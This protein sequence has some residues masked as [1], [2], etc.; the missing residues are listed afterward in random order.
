MNVA[1][2]ELSNITPAVVVADN[3]Q[4]VIEYRPAGTGKTMTL[5]AKCGEEALHVE[6]LDVT[7]SNSRER[8]SDAVC[9]G[10]PGIDRKAVD[11]EL[12]RIAAAAAV[13]RGAGGGGDAGDSKTLEEDVPE[14]DTRRIVR[15]ERFITQQVSGLAVPTARL[16][17]GGPKGQYNLY[18]RDHKDGRRRSLRLP[19]AIDLPSESG[20]GE[21]EKLLIHPRPSEPSVKQQCG[22][23]Q[24]ARRAWVK[25]SVA[26]DPAQVFKAICERFAFFLHLPEQKAPGVTATLSLWTMLTYIYPAFNAVP[27]LY[28]GGP[29]GSGKS[30]VF[31]VLSRLV[32]RP[33]SSSSLTAASLFRTL[34]DRGGTL[35]LDEAE[36]LKQTSAPDVGE[37]LSMLLAGYKRGGQAT[38][39]EPVG[40]SFRTVSFDVYG[41]KVLGCINGLPP[42][43][44]S[45]AIPVTMFR[46]PPGSVKPRHRIDAVP[47]KWQAIR[48]DLH[49]LALEHGPVWLEL[50][51]RD[52]VCSAMSG[53]DFE[54]WQPLLS[55]A[56]W[57]E[58]HGASGLLGL[59]QDHASATIN[60]GRDDTTPD[61]D[62]TLLRILA[63]FIQ[64]RTEPTAGDI[65]ERAK[66]KEP[67]AF[68]SWSARA[69]SGH[70]KRY[71]LSTNKTAGRKLYSHVTVD[72]LLN[73][74]TNYHV[75][76]GFDNE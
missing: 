69:V 57:I 6:S 54:L 40:D 20:S 63:D 23:S 72:T 75:D 4:L 70:L 14:L 22:W 53:R 48:D 43:L 8:F 29:L 50:A 2:T 41:P 18:Q 15:P 33:F 47:H 3:Q 9:N 58:S 7:R 13:S 56:E 28:L 61:C 10:R 1:T 19:S 38:R 36:R 67:R 44:A 39:L 64:S 25:G 68:E 30:R 74:Q 31:E 52:E 55:L 73:I 60:E 5:T 26:P 76:L 65:L 21:T 17:G 66:A 24:S 42:A 34:H 32:F 71:G 45:R 46:S 37:L 49:A 16:T 27:Y 62:E 35:L 59:M 11:D 12:L 51:G